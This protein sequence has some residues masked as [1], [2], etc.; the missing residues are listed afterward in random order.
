MRTVIYSQC[1]DQQQCIFNLYTCCITVNSCPRVRTSTCVR[2]ESV[3]ARGSI[4]TRVGETVVDVVV[5]VVAIVA[6]H[7]I[8]RV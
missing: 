8:A 6:G 2:V 7:A 3:Y 1:T 5:T 4:A